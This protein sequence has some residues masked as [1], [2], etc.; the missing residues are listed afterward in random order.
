[1]N[2]T[3]KIAEPAHAS[4]QKRLLYFFLFIRWLAG[5]AKR[6]IIKIYYLSIPL[7]HPRASRYPPDTKTKAPPMVKGKGLFNVH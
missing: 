5:D 7:N 3:A 1:M 6:S 2:Q 4:D